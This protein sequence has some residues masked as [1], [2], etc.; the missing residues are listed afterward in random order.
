MCL[1]EQWACAGLVLAAR[2][3]PRVDRSSRFSGTVGSAQ[4]SHQFHLVS[5]ARQRVAKC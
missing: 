2:G 5:F 1:A 4:G 3:E